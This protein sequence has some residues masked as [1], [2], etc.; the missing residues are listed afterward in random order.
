MITES[1]SS[2]ATRGRWAVEIRRCSNSGI[3]FFLFYDISESLSF[4]M[5]FWSQV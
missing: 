4:H 2:R 1:D 3:Y 5:L